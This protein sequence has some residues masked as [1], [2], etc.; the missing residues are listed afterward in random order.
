MCRWIIQLSAILTILSGVGAT[1]IDMAKDG[2]RG[3]VPDTPA[4]RMFARVLEV[5]NVDDESGLTAF[6]T[7]NFSSDALKKTPAEKYVKTLSTIRRASGGYDPAFEAP[8]EGNNDHHLAIVVRN[9]KSRALEKLGVQVEP[10]PPHK[11]LKVYRRSTRL[12]SD[13]PD[14]TFT[15][16]M[17]KKVRLKDLRGSFVVLDFWATWCTPCLA[18]M[19]ELQKLHKSFER[20]GVKV[21]A[22]N[23][24]EHMAPTR[25]D[26]EG[27]MALND[28]TYDLV[29]ADDEVAKAFK[30][31][32]LPLVCVLDREG[33]YVYV[34]RGGRR[35]LEHL[36]EIGRLLDARLGP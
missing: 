6:V 22:V 25:H 13:A 17:N 35:G 2:G 8:D 28:L 23:V 20:R 3:L 33:K 10:D 27:Y 24:W 34:G 16:T 9:R 18:M 15:D 36:F 30:L 31:R 7:A 14:V 19:P 11:C 21:I 5:L 4:G 29:F 12:G 26:P 32:S 1:G